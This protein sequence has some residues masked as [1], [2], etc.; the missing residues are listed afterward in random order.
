VK[1]ASSVASITPAIRNASTAGEG[2]LGGGVKV[3]HRQV[4]VGVEQS[5]I[6]VAPGSR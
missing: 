1:P 5:G 2:G 4:H 6:S 3:D